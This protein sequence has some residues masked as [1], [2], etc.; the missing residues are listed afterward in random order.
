MKHF[1]CTKLHRLGLNHKHFPAQKYAYSI[2]TSEEMTKNAVGLQLQIIHTAFPVIHY[3]EIIN[4][5]QLNR[6]SQEMCSSV[7]SALNNV[8][9]FHMCMVTWTALFTHAMRERLP[10]RCIQSKGVAKSRRP[11]K[12]IITILHHLLWQ[13]DKL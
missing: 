12:Q 4:S 3:N 7:P 9:P 8:L 13:Q 2:A 1:V 6:F 5:I 10:Y 11:R